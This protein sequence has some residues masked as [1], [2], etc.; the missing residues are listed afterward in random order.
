MPTSQFWPGYLSP[1]GVIR[2][3]YIKTYWQIMFCFNYAY[4]FRLSF[5]HYISMGKGFQQLKC[6]LLAPNH[7]WVLEGIYC[8]TYVY[9]AVR[10]SICQ[11]LLTGDWTH[12]LPP[13]NAACSHCMQST[14]WLG[15]ALHLKTYKPQLCRKLCPTFGQ[16]WAPR[17]Q[18]HF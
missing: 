2:S 12:S 14:R 15:E 3:Q 13:H 7:L 4:A 16:S 6:N 11:L 9:M 17:E 8:Y 1:K 5:N 10:I 18:R